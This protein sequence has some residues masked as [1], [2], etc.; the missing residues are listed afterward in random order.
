MTPSATGLVPVFNR[1]GSLSPLPPR[2]ANSRALS[3]PPVTPA[4]RC[5]RVEPQRYYPF[6]YR[7]GSTPREIAS[8][9]NELSP[10]AERASVDRTVP[11][12]IKP[13]TWAPR[14]NEIAFDEDGKLDHFFECFFWFC[15]LGRFCF[16]C[17]NIQCQ[18]DF[19]V[20]LLLEEVLYF[21][22]LIL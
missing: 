12:P 22:L 14:P 7:G 11:T 2:L 16:A 5:L 3:L 19:F 18:T 21:V 4:G 10:I 15:I 9:L 20:C 17:V 1:A 8:K 6:S 13:S